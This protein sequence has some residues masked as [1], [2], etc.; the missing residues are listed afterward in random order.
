MKIVLFENILYVHI[1]HAR[2][3]YHWLQYVMFYCYYFN[4]MQPILYHIQTIQRIRSGNL[5]INGCSISF[6]IK[7]FQIE[8]LL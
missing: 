5:Q 3:F 4:T 8:V 6:T 2:F 1:Y 7:A